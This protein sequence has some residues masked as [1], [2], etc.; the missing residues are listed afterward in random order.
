MDPELGV[1]Y[2]QGGGGVQLCS[3]GVEF[4]ITMDIYITF[5]FQGVQIPL[6]PTGYADALDVKLE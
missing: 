6:S 1:Q 5:D 4:L 3:K 2:F